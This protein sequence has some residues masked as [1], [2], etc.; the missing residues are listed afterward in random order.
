MT[1]VIVYCEGP[2]EETFVN[3][4]LAPSFW[5][6]NIYLT[7]S[8]CN[9]VSKYSIIKKDLST[10]CRH[11]PS[12]V[13]TTMLDYYALPSDTPGMRDTVNG[14]IYDK[15]SHV[16]GKI[17]EDIGVD[18]LIPYLMLHEFEALLFSDPTCF[19][20]CGLSNRKIAEL[21]S[22]RD[23][24]ETPEHINNSPNTA[25]SKRILRI[26]PE[27][28]K[29][30]DGFNIAE[31]IGLTTMRSECRHFDKWVNFLEKLEPE[32]TFW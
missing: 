23:G 7:A 21:C 3:R 14:T 22:I 30:L 4:I 10:L 20:Y 28:D 5:S 32:E 8:P 2:T 11:D 18:N 1:R 31:D 16:E 9:G 29:V 25:P 27:Y 13:I 12:A 6:K 19:S 24:V 26:Y 17:K 15:V